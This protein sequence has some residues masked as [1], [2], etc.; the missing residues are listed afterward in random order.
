LRSLTLIAGI[1]VLVIGIFYS[2]WG[3]VFIQFQGGYEITK[4]SLIPTA[5]VLLFA[6][7]MILRK[8]KRDK[9]H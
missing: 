8:Y 7:I 5:I 9:Q 1:I 4:N 3:L 6:A 2:I